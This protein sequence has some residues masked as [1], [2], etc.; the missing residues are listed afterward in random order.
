MLG[1]G[2]IDF[3]CVGYAV[4]GSPTLPG[5]ARVRDADAMRRKR[6]SSKISIIAKEIIRVMH[7]SGQLLVLPLS[8]PSGGELAGGYL[9]RGHCSWCPSGVGGVLHFGRGG[10]FVVDASTQ[11]CS[12][13]VF[14]FVRIVKD[15]D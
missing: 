13:F 2:V 7:R 8:V 11:C 4:A 15:L 14:S 3:A 1:V 12:C 5:A 10:H 9:F 6:V